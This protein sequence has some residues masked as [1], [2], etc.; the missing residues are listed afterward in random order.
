MS[1]LNLLYQTEYPVTESLKVVIPTVGQVLDN[2]D[3]Y[4]SMVTA[5]TAMPIDLMVQLEDLN[6]DFETM[7]DYELF[8]LLSNSLRMQD[9]SLILK[10]ISLSTFQLDINEETQELFLR[11]TQSDVIIDRAAYYQISAVLRKIHNIKKNTRKPGNQEAKEYMLKR[12]RE[13]QK[14][15]LK[16]KTDS[17]T[18]ALIVAMVNSPEYKYDYDSTRKLTIYQFNKSVN[19]IVKRVDYNNKMFGVY[20]GNIDPKNLSRDDLNWLTGK[21]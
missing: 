10:D 2:E 9:T 8:I 7:T 20:T 12:A 21:I 17:Q 3:E 5:F 11:D 14:R 19:Q 16:R 15:A 18:E 4:Y 6:L 1:T 13:K